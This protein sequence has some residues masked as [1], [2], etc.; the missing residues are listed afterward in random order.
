MLLTFSY[1][2][3]SCG[4]CCMSHRK[5]FEN[6]SLNLLANKKVLLRERKRHTV[7]RVVTTPSV[8]L[9]GYPPILTWLG[10][11]PYLG[12][13]PAGYPRQGYPRQGTPLGRVPPSPQQGTPWQGIPRQ[14]TP[15]GCTWQGTPPVSAPWHSEKCCKALWNMGT[16]PVDR[17]IDGWKD[18]RVSK[19]YLPV[20][21]R[22]Q[23]VITAKTIN[24][25]K[26]K[27]TVQTKS[28]NFYR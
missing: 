19:H 21:L 16:P 22:T 14:G 24:G 3:S 15:P 27:N 4:Y 25:T 12:T 13:P 28:L 26:E 17:Q 9:T 10:G 5:L 2:L 6:I 18:R 20:V 11:V 23:A 7:R 1:L 8:V